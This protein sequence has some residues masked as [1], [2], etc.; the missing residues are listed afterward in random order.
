MVVGSQKFTP[1]APTLVTKTYA[2][3]NCH[4]FDDAKKKS[5]GPNL[6]HLASR[7]V[8]ASGD[9]PLTR[10]N[11]IKWVMDAPSL[12]PMQSQKCLQPPPAT[13]V[14]M[15]SFTKNLPSG[16]QPMS[17]QDAETIAGYL[18]AQK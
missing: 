15:P 10:D 5:Y 13:C 1:K 11:L 9:L 14:G 16:K 3:T 18:L 17:T 6:T 8:F 7:E 2:C 4:V 12:I